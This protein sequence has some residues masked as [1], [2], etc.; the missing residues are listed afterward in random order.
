MDFT[1]PEIKAEL[2]EKTFDGA[3]LW[4]SFIAFIYMILVCICAFCLVSVDVSVLL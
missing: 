3:D 1:V 4:K 2:S